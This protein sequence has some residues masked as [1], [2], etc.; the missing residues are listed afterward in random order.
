MDKEAKIER[1]MDT[2][3]RKSEEL[4][5]TNLD[6][7]ITSISDTINSDEFQELLRRLGFS[8]LSQ[9]VESGQAEEHM[10]MMYPIHAN[11]FEF[12]F[13]ENKE[14]L[15]GIVKLTRALI[16]S[17]GLNFDSEAKDLRQYLESQLNMHEEELVHI[18]LKER[19]L[20][21]ARAVIGNVPKVDLLTGTGAIIEYIWMRCANEVCTS[22]LIGKND[23]G[24]Y[25]SGY[26]GIRLSLN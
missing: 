25:I 6:T 13:Y 10:K 16:G 5:E 24:R 18:L 9:W 3:R 11:N 20:Y 21:A 26:Y 22:D 4:F 8:R 23:N 19:G 7:I 12:I 15:N 1:I 17:F 2:Y 14:Q